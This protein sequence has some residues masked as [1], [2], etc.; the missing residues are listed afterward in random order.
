MKDFIFVVG[1]SGVGKST[2]AKGLFEHYRSTYIEQWMIPEFV[3]RDGVEEVTGELEE[4][5]L[6]EA[7]VALMMSFHN[8]GYKNI[9]VS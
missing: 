1:P 6:W 3:T 4:R 2:L 9:V 5:T 7:M 8:L